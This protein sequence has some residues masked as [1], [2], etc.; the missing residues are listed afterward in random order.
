MTYWEIRLNSKAFHS[1]GMCWMPIET[2]F[3][4]T[5]IG[6]IYW[7][8]SIVME[9]MR[10]WST[11]NELLRCT[12]KNAWVREQNRQRQNGSSH[13]CELFLSLWNI[14][15]S[16]SSLRAK[17]F[18]PLLFPTHSI[19]SAHVHWYKVYVWIKIE[20][21]VLLFLVDIGIVYFQIYEFSNM[22]CVLANKI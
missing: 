2:S 4:E 12:H 15:H 17:S 20:R 7:W 13:S 14:F 6:N 3:R 5:L 18:F 11:R 1:V 9:T 22:R 21:A 19:R 10:S 16:S 8:D